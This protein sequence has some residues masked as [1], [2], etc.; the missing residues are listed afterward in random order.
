LRQVT[1][2]EPV[3]PRL[4]NTKVP[5][6]LETICL[7]AMSKTSD[8]RFVDCQ[9][10]ADD[11]RRWQEGEPVQRGERRSDLAEAALARR[12]DQQQ[13]AV[14]GVLFKQSDRARQDV[15]MSSGLLHLAQAED[16]SLD[17]GQVLL[18]HRDH[19]KKW[20]DVAVRP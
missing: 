4:L 2:T 12:H 3:S 16:F 14:L 13:I 5:R 20:A 7:K 15:R 8:H 11:L 1:D 10:M 9:E 19:I 6:D 17:R 18:V